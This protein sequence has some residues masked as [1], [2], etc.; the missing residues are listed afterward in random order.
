MGWTTEKL[1]SICDRFREFSFLQSIQTGYVQC[2]L[3]IPAHSPGVQQMGNETDHSIPS[4]ANA[5]Y[6]SA[7]TSTPTQTFTAYTVYG[8]LFL[9]FIT[10][11]ISEL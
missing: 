2:T 6:Y 10:L 7:H 5:T 4:S 1:W 9:Y 3:C 11:E 8:K